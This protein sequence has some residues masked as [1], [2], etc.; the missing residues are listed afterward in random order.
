MTRCV[1]GFLLRLALTSITAP[2]ELQ[3]NRNKR[4]R[5]SDHPDRPGCDSVERKNSMPI[6]FSPFSYFIGGK[7]LSPTCD[8][9]KGTVRHFHISNSMIEAKICGFQE[10]D[11]KKRCWL[12][13]EL[14]RLR[15]GTA[16]HLKIHPQ[17]QAHS[18]KPLL[19]QFAHQ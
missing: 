17:R 6:G 7:S 15:A 12:T 10:P 11:C 1:R 4:L 2:T 13:V 3:L 16:N 19:E 14:W 8:S 18:H 5:I 9:L